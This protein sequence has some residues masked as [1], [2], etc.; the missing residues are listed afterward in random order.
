MKTKIILTNPAKDFTWAI[1]TIAQFWGKAK[2]EGIPYADMKDLDKA[3][4]VIEAVFE[5]IKGG[6]VQP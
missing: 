2:D 6:M 3:E 5:W 1:T 4:D